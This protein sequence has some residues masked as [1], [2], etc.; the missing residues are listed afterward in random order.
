MEEK[1][2][3]LTQGLPNAPGADSLPGGAPLWRKCAQNTSQPR[4]QSDMQATAAVITDQ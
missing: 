4:P 3:G 2:R 1:Q